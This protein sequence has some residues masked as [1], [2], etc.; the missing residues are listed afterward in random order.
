M[1]RARYWTE[2]EGEEGKSSKCLLLRRAMIFPR[3]RPSVRVLRLRNEH[4]HTHTPTISCPSSLLLFG[5]GQGIHA[6]P[7]VGCHILRVFV[8]SEFVLTDFCVVGW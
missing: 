4:T 8:L 2:S 5:R 6:L 7:T 3:F 1:V